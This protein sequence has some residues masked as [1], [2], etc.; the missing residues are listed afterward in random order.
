MVE[1]DLSTPLQ[2]GSLFCLSVTLKLRD[3]RGGH[4]PLWG[5]S[6]FCAQYGRFTTHQGQVGETQ[7]EWTM[8]TQIEWWQCICTNPDATRLPAM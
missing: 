6:F 1:V 7:G 4:H 3:G 8:A 2:K 5:Q